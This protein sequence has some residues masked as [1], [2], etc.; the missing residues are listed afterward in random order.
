MNPASEKKT[1]RCGSREDVE[2][3]K[4][5]ILRAAT[6][7]FAENGFSDAITQALADRLGVGKG[8]IYRHFPSKRELFLAAADRVMRKL[9]ER[10]LE[11]VEGVE[12]GLEQM[13][14]GILAFLTFFAERPEYV[15]LLILERAEFKDRAR[16]TYIEHRE[17]HTKRW[18]ELYGRLIAE[19][20]MRDAPPERIS[21][22]VGNLI[23]GTMFTNYFA[24][25]GKPVVEQARDILDIVFQGVLT[26]SGRA[27]LRNRSFLE[28]LQR[29]ADS[30]RSNSNGSA[31][32]PPEAASAQH[33]ED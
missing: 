22:V 32:R 11:S 18:R 10:V 1:K 13:A 20:R 24:G 30:S 31:P 27:G 16:P 21:D 14:R 2:R 6:E 9:R 26:E 33:Q 5:E 29:V 23:Y 4:E 3:R 17:V 28:E 8:T 15:E 25:P 7:L 19:G 12:D